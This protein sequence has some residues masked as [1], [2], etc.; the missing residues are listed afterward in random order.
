LQPLD[1]YAIIEEHLDF[2][3][4]I[5]ALYKAIGHTVL[6]KEPKTLIDIGCG[7]G[8]FVHIMNY[9]GIDAFGV[10]K[11]AKQ[12]EIAQSKGIDTQCID[13][14]DIK[15][16]YECATAVFDVINYIPKEYLK[17][18]LTDTYKLLNDGGYFIFDLNTLFGFQEVATGTLNIDKSDK[19]IAIDAN[20]KEDKLYTDITLFEQEGKLYTKQT[21]TIIQ[22]YHQNSS[23]IEVLNNIGFNVEDTID[24]NLHSDEESD[25]QIYICKKL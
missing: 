2:E 9:N 18:F 3:E 20:F 13:I 21:G 6:S 11:S 19:F 1:L 17:E 16:K 12:I 23:L 22:Y 25:K 7:Q 8:D 4:E 15:Q 24:F 14:K 5:H 10:D